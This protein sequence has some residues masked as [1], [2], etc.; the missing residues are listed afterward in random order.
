MGLGLNASTNLGGTNSRNLVTGL[1]TI[2]SAF[3]L[4]T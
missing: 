2:R 1:M 4:R 3:F